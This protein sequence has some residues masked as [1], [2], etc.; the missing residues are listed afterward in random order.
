MRKPVAT[1]R[2]IGIAPTDTAHAGSTAFGTIPLFA[3]LVL[4]VGLAGAAG[5]ALAHIRASVLAYRSPI[6]AQ[7]ALSG[8]STTPL[9]DQVVIVAIGGLRA[10]AIADM[11]TLQQLA[12]QAATARVV[13]S[14]ASSSQAQWIALVSGSPPELSGAPLLNLPEEQMRP[15][16]TDTIFAAAQRAGLT[17]AIVGLSFWGRLVPATSLAAHYSGQ[18][19]ASE[20]DRAAAEAAC[21]YLRSFRPHLSLVQLQ[22]LSDAARQ[23]GDSSSAY[24][25]SA[26]TIDEHLRNISACI[27][28]HNAVL[29]VTSCPDAFPLSAVAGHRSRVGTPLIVVGSP[30]I[31][32]DHGTVSPVDIAPT[33]CALLGAPTPR[34]STGRVLFRMLAA[35][36]FKLAETQVEVALQRREHATLYLRSIGQGTLSDTAIGDVDVALSSLQVGNV[37]S[38]YHLADLATERI[39]T[40]ATLARQRRIDRERRQRLPLTALAIALPLFLLLACY[41]RKALLLGLAAALS[42]ATFHVSAGVQG[43]ALVTGPFTEPHLLLRNTFPSMAAATAMGGIILLAHLMHSQEGSAI[44]VVKTSLSYSFAVIYCLACQIAVIYW[45]QGWRLTWYLPDMSVFS[46]QQL[47]LTQVI[48]AAA[49]GLVLPPALL[50]A[51]LLYQ[52]AGLILRRLQPTYQGGT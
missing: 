36:P 38:A 39:N 4:L 14:L 44:A 49:L 40:E 31:V 3:G 2:P 29:L 37:E 1:Q 24:R 27:N 11:P 35:N 26:R 12:R 46:W 50:L 8:H 16:A 10:E 5:L 19:S 34:A 9:A 17:T 42:L 48:A 41:R 20:A 6:N 33:V 47:A 25:Q 7:P 28:W 30:V 21:R 18:G 15:P 51:G 32:G 45:L 52:L 22:G 13:P 23:E 43:L